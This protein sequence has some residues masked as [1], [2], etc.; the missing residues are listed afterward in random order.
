MFTSRLGT[1]I[2]YDFILSKYGMDGIRKIRKLFYIKTVGHNNKP[3]SIIASSIKKPWICIPRFGNHILKKRKM[4][5]KID[6]KLQQG[7]DIELKS[8]LRSTKNQQIVLNYLFEKVYNEERKTRTQHLVVF[9]KWI[10][11]LHGKHIFGYGFDTTNQE[12]T[13][14]IVPNTYLLNQWVKVITEIF[15]ITP[16]VYYGKKKTDG[17]IIVSVINSLINYEHYDDCGLIIYDEVH[18]YCSKK[19]SKIFYTMCCIGLT[20]TPNQ[21]IDKFDPV[22]K[23]HL[24]PIIYSNKIQQWDPDDVTYTT[25]VHRVLYSGPP[26][27]TK[28]ILSKSGIVSVPLMLNQIQNDPYRNKMITEY[29][30]DLYKNDKNVFIFSDRR[31][32][33]HILANILLDQNVNV[34][35]PELDI[36]QLMGGST[37]EDITQAKK[38]RIILTTYAYSGTGVSITKMNSL[39]FRKSNMEQILGRIY[40]LSSDCTINREIVDV[41]D[42]KVCLKSQY[43]TRKKNLQ[44]T[45]NKIIDK[46]IKW[47]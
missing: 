34:E 26:E 18:M 39:I 16:G 47:N 8:S 13:F 45:R 7:V 35:V 17:D 21:R 4:V 15:N 3:K 1:F 33:L 23:W 5:D 40:R 31:E 2:D 27:Y 46:K 44:Q 24:G 9:Y 41:V 32:H 36:K 10:L 29:V 25:T 37:E 6:N 28:M 38:S 42:V 12:K 22:A 20:A 43:Y 14:I 30:I 11:K 19:F